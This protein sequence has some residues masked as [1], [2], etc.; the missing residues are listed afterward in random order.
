MIRNI[1]LASLTVA[2][3]LLCAALVAIFG[4]LGGILAGFTLGA[5]AGYYLS[6]INRGRTWAGPDINDPP[7]MDQH[8][9]ADPPRKPVSY[10]DVRPPVTGKPVSPVSNEW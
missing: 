7:L 10:A 4:N 8:P 2:I 5:L 9:P 3:G 6:I 1:T